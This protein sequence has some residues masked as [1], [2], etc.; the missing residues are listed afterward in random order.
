MMSQLERRLEA[1]SKLALSLDVCNGVL[2]G[3]GIFGLGRRAYRIKTGCTTFEFLRQKNAKPP[4]LAKFDMAVFSTGLKVFD[5]KTLSNQEVGGPTLPA[6]MVD[7]AVPGVPIYILS[8][9]AVLGLDRGGEVLKLVSPAAS[10]N[11]FEAGDWDS[12]VTHTSPEPKWEKPLE[13]VSLA[14]ATR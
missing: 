14:P 9:E 5:G 2:S 4:S 3:H 10:V 1:Y 8:Q 13:Q 12:L 7:R 6:K 11:L